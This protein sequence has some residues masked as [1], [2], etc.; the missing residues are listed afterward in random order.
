MAIHVTSEI[1]PLRRVLLHRPGRELEHLTPDHLEKLLFDDI[2]YLAA[3][4]R[5]HDAFAS[6]LRANGVEVVYLADLVAEALDAAPRAR[7]EFVEDFIRYAGNVARN[8]H[9]Q[10]FRFLLGIPDNRE[11]VLK[12][13]AG[14][15]IAELGGESSTPLA[16]LVLQRDRFVLEPIPNLYFT[17]DPFAC[18][19]DGVSLNRMR[20]STRRRETIYG[21]Y[22]LRYHPDYTGT[23]LYYHP[24]DPFVIE[25]GDVLNLSEKVL[26]VG[27]SQRTEPEAIEL[28]A[29][30]I[31]TSGSSAIE[32]VL[33]LD[34]PEMRAF[35]HLDTVLTQVSENC[36]VIHP[37][38]LN[39][40]RV[41]E[42]TRNGLPGEIKATE[43][44]GPLHQILGRALGRDDVELIPCGGKDRIASEREQWNDASNTLCLSPG[45][46]AVYDRN[47]VTNEIL[48]RHGF[49]VLEL[50]SSELSR[51]RGGPR[52]MSMPLLRAADS[53]SKTTN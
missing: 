49:T 15:N 4:C 20:T 52:C 10:L 31:F 27:I 37:G 46:V 45:V 7:A 2:P 25:G 17:R 26:A 11:L 32:R 44:S 23:P 36:F 33:A 6:L 1:Q 53:N 39:T 50:P 41:Y 18:I 42:I 14:V 28:L 47:V 16:D 43:L 12:T 3:A 48:R 9:D 29:R 34:I 22:I 8:Y 40:L 38:I 24:S 51:G 13:M 30:H 19:G 35:M 21:E 5:E